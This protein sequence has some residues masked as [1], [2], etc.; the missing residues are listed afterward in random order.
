[1]ATYYTNEN[2]PGQPFVVLRSDGITPENLNDGSWTAVVELI[3]DGPAG[4]VLVATQSTDITLA[5]PSATD[6]VNLTRTKWSASTL[7]SVVTA[8]GTNTTLEVR[9]HPVLTRSGTDKEGV[10]TGEPVRH[11]FKVRP[12]A[13]P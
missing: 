11:T 8:L 6:P 1:M 9:E 3:R 7:A 2:L 5:T 4:E 10:L 12:V 13:G